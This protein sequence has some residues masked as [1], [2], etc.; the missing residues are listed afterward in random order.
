MNTSNTP[1]TANATQNA[2]T[3]TTTASNI[4]AA[5]LPREQAHASARCLSREIKMN[6]VMRTMVWITGVAFGVFTPGAYAQS[7]MGAGATQTNSEFL[8]LDA[9]HDGLVSREEAKQNAAVN[10]AFSQADMNRDGRL[11][12]NELIKALSIG[13]GETI[14]G[15]ALEGGSA[16]KQYAV[17]AEITAKVKAA[18]L[19]EEGLRSLDVSVQTYR[20]KV[21]LAGFID[22]KDQIAQA[23]KI[24]AGESGV[25]SVLNNLAIK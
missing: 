18:L 15:I 16:A 21:Q 4:R 12:E 1:R 17:D 5:M 23:G 11:D 20:G 8:K 9:D 19:G 25:R 10:A 13:R 14:A 6:D 7:P 2:A 22:S 3:T 24:A